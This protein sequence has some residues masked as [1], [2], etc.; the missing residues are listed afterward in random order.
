[1]DLFD[2]IEQG[3]PDVRVFGKK[4]GNPYLQSPSAFATA[5][6]K[7]KLNEGRSKRDR[8]VFHSIRHT[9]AIRLARHLGARDL[10]DVMG[11]RTVQMAM[12]YV[13]ANEDA[14]LYFTRSQFA[15]S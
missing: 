15:H 8:V 13:H 9:V 5:V 3:S 2:S 12:R 6:D 11:W 4:D 10:M 14:K 1:L 7:L